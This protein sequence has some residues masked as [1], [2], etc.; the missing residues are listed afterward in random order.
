MLDAHGTRTAVT[1]RPV[2]GWD[3]AR[4]EGAGRPEPH[5]QPVEL[6]TVPTRHGLEA[7]DILRLG[8]GVGPVLHDVSG[9][10][11]GFLVPPGTAVRWRLPGS[12]C[13]PLCG[14]EQGPMR[15]P[16]VSNAGWL[17]APEVAQ[18]RLTEAAR[19]RAALLEALR[20]LAA[21]DGRL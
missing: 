1:Y 2:R 19:L 12:A 20:T 6:V 18:A 17:V 3:A 7:L 13:V 16:P 9:D 4:P 5:W 21:A 15:K 10:T 8:G 11:M 14:L